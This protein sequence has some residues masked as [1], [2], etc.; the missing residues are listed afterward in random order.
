MRRSPLEAIGGT[1]VRQVPADRRNIARVRFSDMLST[2]RHD[3]HPV[4]VALVPA[5]LD[6]GDNAPAAL[7][8][9]QAS[10]AQRALKNARTA[11]SSPPP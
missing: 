8:R 4:T 5:Q 1:R 6:S 2:S 3:A 7:R 10:S 11:A 9:L